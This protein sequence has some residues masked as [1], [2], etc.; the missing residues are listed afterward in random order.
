MKF[1]T[2]VDE[3]TGAIDKVSPTIDKKAP[4]GA[5]SIFVDAYKTEKFQG[6]FLYTTNLVAEVTVRMACTV[7]EPGRA[8]ILPEQLRAGLADRDPNADV[9]I[10][11]VAGKRK[12]DPSR[13]RVTIGKDHFFLGYDSTGT[14]AMLSRMKATPFQQ[15]PSYT[16]PGKSMV[17]LAHR[18]LFCVPKENEGVN[19]LELSGMRVVATAEGY[20]AHASD[21]HVCAL[22]RVKGEEGTTQRH[23][24]FLLPNRAVPPLVKL[25]KR[26]TEVQVIEGS[27]NAS[28]HMGKMFFKMGTTFF[29]SRL[30][31][32]QFPNISKALEVQAAEFW[33]TVDR[34][35]LRY[36]LQRAQSFNSLHHVQLEFNK[37]TLVVRA[38]GEIFELEEKLDL[39]SEDLPTDLVL[40]RTINLD[41]LLNIAGIS[42]QERLKL[43]VSDYTQTTKAGKALIVADADDYVDCVYAIMPISEQAVAVKAAA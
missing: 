35:Q 2:K 29:G 14:D 8:L 23:D 26:E 19:R 11:L 17:A 21:G 40:T 20:E 36:T 15:K 22:I 25:V 32:G 27:K 39:E 16:I 41:Y 38:K 34:E 7:D 6:I 5:A 1:T 31:E 13:L 10:A 9:E 18:G 42:S 30:L 12:A 24:A 33:V 37:N 43:G 3:L 4:A 28:G